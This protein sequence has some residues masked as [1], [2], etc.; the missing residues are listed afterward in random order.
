MGND[1]A[2]AIIVNDLDSMVF[3]IEAL[4]AHP[5]Y[6]DALLLVQ[7]ARKAIENGR[8]DLHQRSMTERFGTAR[9]QSDRF[10]RL[11]PSDD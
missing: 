8:S 6:T 5:S 7:N 9:A 11:E 1:S 2:A 10:A 3:R 4:P